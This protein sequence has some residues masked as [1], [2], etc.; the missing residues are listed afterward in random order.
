M[1]VRQLGAGE[2]KVENQYRRFVA[3][4][5]K[6]ARRCARWKKTMQLRPHFEWRGLGSIPYR[7]SAS[8]RTYA[9]WDAESAIRSTR[10]CA[11]P[12]RAPRSAATC[13]KAC[14][15]R[16]SARSSASDCTPEHPVGALMVSSEG[17]CAAHY[18]YAPR[19][20]DGRTLDVQRPAKRRF[21]DTQ[22]EMAHGAGGK[23]SRRLVEGLIAPYFANPVLAAFADA[24]RIPY[25]D[26]SLATTADGFVVK[27]LQ[28]PGGSIGELAVNGTLN[29][30]AVSG[31]KPLA[32][33]G[34]ASSWRRVST[35]PCSSAR[36]RRWPRRASGPACRS[37][38][39]TRRSSST[40]WPTA[41]TSRRS[42]SAAIDARVRLDPRRCVRAIACCSRDRSAITASRSCWRAANSI[43]KPTCVRT[44]A[45]CGRSWRRCSNVCRRTIRWMRDPTRGGVATALNELVRG[46]P[47]ASRS[48]KR[49]C[50]CTTR[51]AAR[52]NCSGSIRCTSPTKDSFSPSSRGRRGGALAALRAVPGGEARDVHRRS[53]REPKG[54]VVGV[55]SYGGTR[56][57]R[58]AR[59]GSAAAHLLTGLE[60]VRDAL[61]AAL[62]RAARRTDDA[63]TRVRRVSTWMPTPRRARALL[64]LT[65]GPTLVPVLV[66][67]GRVVAIGLRGRGCYVGPS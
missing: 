40:A 18:R 38:A 65:Q 47:T 60:S 4:R 12:T 51:C 20:A 66:E 3:R 2:A 56:V 37:S 61:V 17:A 55:S 41:C 39:A 48:S 31:A 53:A 36:S 42:A 25:G 21:R 62:R 32:S 5:R 33:D 26:A 35:R 10:A 44:R 11:S 14:S 8:S 28:F 30:L 27:P 50:R 67:D 19:R 7:R 9:A 13:S 22:I 16:R 45:A 1:V 52:A 43:S 49:R 15:S 24:A 64:A 46:A 6:R 63:G 23:A 57:D 29:D 54:R 59:R 58:H 34:D